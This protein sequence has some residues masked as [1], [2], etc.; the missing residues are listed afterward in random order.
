MSFAAVLPYFRARMSALGYAEWDDSFNFKN[1]PENIV[2]GAYHLEFETATSGP[3]N[4]QPHRFDSP[5]ILR[6]FFKGYRDTKQ[7]RDDALTNAD[8]ILAEIL[9]PNN[10]LGTTLKDIVPSTIDIVTVDDSNDNDIILEMVFSTVFYCVF[11]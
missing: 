11:T 10:R 4:Q 5:V 7:V 8:T 9:D 1:I 6:V 2:N 3:A